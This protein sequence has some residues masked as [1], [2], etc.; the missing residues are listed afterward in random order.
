LLNLAQEVFESLGEHES[1]LDQRGL[2]TAAKIYRK[3]VFK[4]HPDR[5]TH[6]EIMTDINE[7]WQAIQAETARST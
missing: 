4:Y 5:G 3:L 2:P 1:Q 7:L 6:P